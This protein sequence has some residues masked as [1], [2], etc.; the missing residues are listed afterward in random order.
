MIY[1]DELDPTASN[2]RQSGIYYRVMVNREHT[3]SIPCMQ[4]FDEPD[5]DQ[6]RFLT[7]ETFDTQELAEDW[8]L[9]N[10]H[11]CEEALR[12]SKLTG[13]PLFAA[14]GRRRR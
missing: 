2:N 12:A 6:K 14:I 7:E 11:V 4:D 13:Y 8:V 1:E 3:I 10:L 9:R 5:Y